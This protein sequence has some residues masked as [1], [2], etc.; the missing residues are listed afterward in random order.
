MIV[1]DAIGAISLPPHLSLGR[2]MPSS[3]LEV[4][5]TKLANAFKL[6]FGR[7]KVDVK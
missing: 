7:L 2:L 6:E 1:Y 3:S 5:S 4:A